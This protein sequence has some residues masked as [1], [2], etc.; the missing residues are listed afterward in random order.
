MLRSCK[1]QFPAPNKTEPQNCRKKNT[2]SGCLARRSHLS[3]F[4]FVYQCHYSCIAPCYYCRS[5]DRSASHFIF[6]V[7]HSVYREPYSGSGY[8]KSSWSRWLLLEIAV[9]LKFFLC[10]HLYGDRFDA[11]KCVFANR[12]VDHLCQTVA[13]TVRR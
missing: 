8:H 10:F 12:G 6:Y 7:Y 5:A 1:Q 2:L 11:K 13:V 4:W 9:G 3:G